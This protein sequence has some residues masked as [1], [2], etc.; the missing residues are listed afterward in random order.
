MAPPGVETRV[1][2]YVDKPLNFYCRH[3]VDRLRLGLHGRPEPLHQVDALRRA[4]V[5]EDDIYIDVASGAKAGRPKL[6][7]ICKLLRPGDTLVVTGLDRLGRSVVHLVT[8]GGERRERGVGLKVVEQGIDTATIEGRAMFAM[9]SVLAELQRELIVANTRDGLAAARARGR[10]PRL[11][12]HHDGGKHTVQRRSRR[13]RRRP[14]ESGDGSGAMV[15][16]LP[17]RRR[18]SGFASTAKPGAVAAAAARPR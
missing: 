9:L 10:R 18:V 1:D 5:A 14:G 11:T 13:L 16:P 6:D 4:C 17:V 3:H 15:S 12:A 2:I 7:L 8:L